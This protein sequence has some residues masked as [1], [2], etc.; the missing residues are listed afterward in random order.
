[1]TDIE[2]VHSASRIDRKLPRVVIIATGGTLASVA[3]SAAQTTNYGDASLEADALLSEV[4]AI[5]KL[6]TVTTI[7]F[8]MIGSEHMT[9]EILINL[10][11]V[12]DDVFSADAPDGLVITHGSDTMEETATFLDLTYNGHAP[13]VLVAAMRPAA[14]LSA[15]GPFNLYQ[16][17]SLAA[18]PT[19][20]GRGVMMTWSNRIGSAMYTTKVSSRAV[21]AFD[22]GDKGLVGTFVDHRPVFYYPPSRSSGHPYLDVSGRG[23]VLP[24]VAI[25]YGH[26]E[27]DAHLLRL[28]VDHG[29]AGIVVAC[30]GDGTLPLEWAASEQKLLSAGIPVVRS[31]RLVSTY[32]APRKGCITAGCYNPQKARILLMLALYAY[33]GSNISKIQELFDPMAL[34][35]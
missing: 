1:M 2:S 31:S 4:P 9:S 3:K 16:A 17:V 11:N 30:T 25:L 12:I 28:V 29:A 34:E 8:C 5:N 35:I 19:A 10:R 13:I 32:I 18:S 22:A 21:D 33:Q 14:A 27:M 6:A 26:Q 23:V 7:Q 24:K 20:C 15:D